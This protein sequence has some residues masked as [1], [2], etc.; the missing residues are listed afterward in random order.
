[1]TQYQGIRLIAKALCLTVTD[2]TDFVRDL[3]SNRWWLI[4]CKEG[5][6]PL[7]QTGNCYAT[8]D[9]LEHGGDDSAG[10]IHSVG[11]QPI[12]GK[13]IAVIIS[14]KSIPD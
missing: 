4:G 6:Q 2:K 9:R 13:V 11:S 1:M 3:K 10:C 7:P 8:H 5:D 14:G 12:A